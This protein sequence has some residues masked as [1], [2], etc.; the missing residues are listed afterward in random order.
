MSAAI[1][2]HSSAPRHF[3]DLKDFS[4]AELRALLDSA[5]QFKRTR[6]G[7]KNRSRARLWR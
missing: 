7:G 3:L 4:G 5:A 2:L 1:E 6:R